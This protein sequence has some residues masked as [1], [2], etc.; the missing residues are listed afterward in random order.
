MFTCWN[1]KQLWSYIHFRYL[2]RVLLHVYLK[3]FQKKYHEMSYF[4]NK[5]KWMTKTNLQGEDCTWIPAQVL[6]EILG[7]F[8][9][10]PLEGQLPDEQLTGLLV[11]PDFSKSHRARS[12]TVGFLHT[13]MACA[14]HLIICH[15]LPVPAPPWLSRFGC[16]KWMKNWLIRMTK[17]LHCKAE[18][19]FT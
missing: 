2:K 5:M 1:L 4:K 15:T 16:W 14:P 6:L 18:R 17:F 3:L 9:H 19:S 11:A 8:P 10:E 7:D 12:V 13:S